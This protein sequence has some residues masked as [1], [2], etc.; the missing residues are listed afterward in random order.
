M[1]PVPEWWWSY[2]NLGN[3]IDKE[4]QGLAFRTSLDRLV[5]L[6]TYRTWGVLRSW[7]QLKSG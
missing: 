5:F 1:R 7:R 6:R 2:M 3:P 4:L